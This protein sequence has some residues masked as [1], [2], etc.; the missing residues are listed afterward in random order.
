VRFC[1]L[2]NEIFSTLHCPELPEWT[3]RVDSLDIHGLSLLEVVRRIRAAA[4]HY[5]VLVLDG[6]A[7]AEQVAAA[8][9]ARMRRP[10]RLLLTCAQWKRGSSLP[11]RLLRDAGM[12][13]M[14]GSHVTYC[15]VSNWELERFPQ[16]WRVP[17]AQ[18]RFTPSCF[19]ISPDDLD[20][21]VAED[22]GIFSGGDSL[23]D[24]TPLLEAVGGIEVPVTIA[25]HL[26]GAE[27]DVPANVS[28]GGVSRERFA[29]LNR[30]AA[31]VVVALADASDRTA[32]QQSYLNAMAL[33]KSVIVTDA[34]GVREYVEDR[35]TGLIVPLGDAGAMSAALRW[36]LDPANKS[37]VDSIRHRARE[38]VRSRYTWRNYIA[39]IMN[40]VEE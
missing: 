18:V 23:R 11:D 4:D 12:R 17:P 34:P 28:V 5:R 38:M 24:Y 30:R 9:I 7:R 10:P 3:E 19:T 31:V 25:T 8:Y 15:V 32:G 37:E 21:P 35:K 20:L 1:S 13:A 14:R 2:G 29:E 39:S 26:L 40:V 6:T 33:G 36:L 22:W 16:I 27:A